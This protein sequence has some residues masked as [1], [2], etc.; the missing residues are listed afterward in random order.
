MPQGLQVW[1]AS[2]NII[3]DTSTFILKEIATVS[4]NSGT[5]SSGSV[6]LPSGIPAILG[7]STEGSSGTQVGTSYNTGT[8]S[9]D[10]QGYAGGGGSTVYLKVLAL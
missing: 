5:S 3:I 8:N 4:V 2:G 6:S 9:L 1:D 7:V 10:Y